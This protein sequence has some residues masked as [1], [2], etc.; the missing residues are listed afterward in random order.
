[1]LAKPTIS[2]SQGTAIEHREKVTFYCDTKD[3]NITIH[4]VS[5][6]RPLVFHERLQLS[7]DGKTLTILTVQREDAGNY[8]CEAWGARQIQRSDPTFLMVN[9]ESL[10][11]LPSPSLTPTSLG[12]HSVSQL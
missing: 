5:N 2:V 4:W 12:S 9:C 8:Q 3:V 1:M 7:P 6:N 10:S 11:I